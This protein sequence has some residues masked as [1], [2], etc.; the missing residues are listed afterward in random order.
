MENIDIFKVLNRSQSLIIALI[1]NS[2]NMEDEEMNFILSSFA[3]FGLGDIKTVKELVAIIDPHGEICE[4]RGYK[5]YQKEIIDAL[6]YKVEELSTKTYVLPLKDKNNT[7]MSFL[8]N[9]YYDYK[10][11]YRVLLFIKLD[12]QSSMVSLD[13]Y[14]S[15][16][17]KDRL[18]GLFNLNTC[19]EHLKTNV[20]EIYLCLFDLNKFKEI[21]DNFGH[22][23]G[24]EILTTIA[25]LLIK[26]ASANEIFYRRSGDEFIIMCF[27]KNRD[28]IFNLIDKI[29]D[30]MEE[31]TQNKFKN[32]SNLHLSASFGVIHLLANY[33][34]IP[35]ENYYVNALMLA[36][37]AMYQAKVNKLRKVYIEASKCK[38]IIEEKDVESL[39]KELQSKIRR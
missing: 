2:K 24:D 28:Y 35:K 9:M 27:N 12:R 8:L 4:G 36:D 3:S 6:P 25:S 5:E 23:F 10:T 11:E 34:T 13:Y 38:Q 22:S 18:T 1:K 29:S 39:I 21:N 37:Y 17:Y 16:S 30:Y 26:V 33:Q 14:I 32:Y 31:A 20:R 19:I 15:G 7:K